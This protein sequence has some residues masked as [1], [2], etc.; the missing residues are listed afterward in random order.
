MKRIATFTFLLAFV[1][2][3][4]GDVLSAYQVTG[5][6]NYRDREQDQTG[7]TGDEPLLPIRGA[8]VEVL[9]NNT[10]AIL[11]TGVTNVSGEIN[12]NV[13]DNQVRDIVVRVLTVSDYNPFLNVKTETWENFGAGDPYA[14][15]SQVYADHD[16]SSDLDIGTVVAEPQ[17][18]G[19]PFNIFDCLVNQMSMVNAMTGENP[20]SY[21]RMRA[22]FTHGQH[23]G[24]AFY[25]G[26]LNIGAEFPYDDGVVMHE[27]GHFTNSHWSEDDNPGGAH[28][29][30]DVNQDPRLS[31]GEGI[32]SYWHSTTAAMFGLNPPANLEVQTTG[33]PGPGHLSFYV[34]YEQPNWG[35]YGPACEV[36]VT[37]VLYDI[38][39]NENWDDFTPGEGEDFD[40]LSL[41]FDHYWYLAENVLVDPVWHPST[42]EDAWDAWMETFGDTA[43]YDEMKSIFASH[44]MEFWEDDFEVDNTKEAA[45][46][47]GLGET[48]TRHT[49]FPVDDIDWFSMQGIAGAK[50]QIAAMNKMPATHSLITVYESDGTTYVADNI[51]PENPADVG[52]SVELITPASDL[53][54]ITVNQYSYSGIYT[55]YGAYDLELRIIQAPD[56]SAKIQVTPAGLVVTGLPVGETAEEEFTINN[57]GGGPLHFSIWDRERYGEDPPPATWISESPDTGTIEANGS[58]QIT[59]L[60]DA[61]GLHPDTTYDA[62]IFVDSNDMVNP[63]VSIIVRLTTVAVGIDGDDVTGSILPKVF[64]LNQNFPNPFN[65]S[66]SVVYDVPVSVEGTVPVKLIVYNTRG[67]K[68][69]TL[70]NQPKA[71]GRYTVHWDG[72]NGAGERV[73][74]GIYFYKITAGDFVKVKKMVLLK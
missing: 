12:I 14:V 13:N 16:P 6:F 24:Q 71:P 46:T 5:T 27:G 9:D 52:G 15:E 2:L 59:A 58:M 20:G 31:Y 22:K 60:I 35:S 49:L 57:I 29:V 63:E 21:P 67:Q 32:A 19:E 74:S 51:N 3:C 10:S 69:K 1:M 11:A 25:D 48:S 39:D 26:A 34:E 45:T 66:T 7:F 30:G 70:V 37:A 41:S 53:F 18:P 4:A 43:Y 23:S 72:T 73:S 55:E 64:A 40:S 68:V 65:P 17:G 61:T 38:L 8:D 47:I 56:D 28:Y 42:V 54:Y 50:F 62:M 44:R 33:A 36:A